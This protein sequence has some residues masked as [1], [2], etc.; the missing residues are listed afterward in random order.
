M[1]N[2]QEL[3]EYLQTLPGDTKVTCCNDVGEYYSV[4]N[5]VEVEDN[6]LDYTSSTKTLKIGMF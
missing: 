4:C 6:Y 3:I 5:E 1:M 2:V